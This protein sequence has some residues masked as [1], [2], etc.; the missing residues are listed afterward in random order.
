MIVL[1][2]CMIKRVKD[3]DW[4]ICFCRFNFIAKKLY[5][6][7][8]QLG[9]TN[10]QSLGLADDQHDLGYVYGRQACH[11]S[12]HHHGTITRFLS[13]HCMEN[14]QLVCFNIQ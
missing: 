3:K 13:E 1:D 12:Q 2:H 6:R 7:L 4:L 11:G 8:I 9:G 14:S 10:L 5:K